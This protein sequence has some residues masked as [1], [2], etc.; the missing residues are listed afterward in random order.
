MNMRPAFVNYNL[1]CIVRCQAFKQFFEVMYTFE[2]PDQSR[3]VQLPFIKALSTKW[4]VKGNVFYNLLV[5]W[6]E[7]Q[8]Y[9]TTFQCSSTVRG[10]LC[11][12]ANLIKDMLQD[13]INYLYFA[14]A[15]ATPK[16]K[17]SMFCFNALMLTHNNFHSHCF[18]TTTVHTTNYMMRR[19]I[20]K[21]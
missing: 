20:E 11:Y 10:D 9:F 18:F 2:D 19:E 14:F 7:L 3:S 13:R 12:I 8:S 6:E 15:F 21:P 4:L 1:V 16:V 17:Q 5:N